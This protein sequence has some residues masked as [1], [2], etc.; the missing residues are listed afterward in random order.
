MCRAA[1]VV[2]DLGEQVDQ[3]VEVSIDRAAVDDPGDVEQ[4]CR[5]SGLS[6][7]GRGLGQVCQVGPLG[8]CPGDRVRQHAGGVRLGELFSGEPDQLGDLAG[9][10]QGLGQVGVG[11]GDRCAFGDEFG[12]CVVTPQ[13]RRVRHSQRLILATALE[14][15]A[16]AG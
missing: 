3:G 10:D 7:A 14:Q 15:A 2:F 16:V 5:G 9:L 6:N 12:G 13:R 4:T 1:L 8:D 11:L